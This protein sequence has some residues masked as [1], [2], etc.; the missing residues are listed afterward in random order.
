[1]SLITTILIHFAG[2]AVIVLGASFLISVAVG[3]FI[4]G[5]FGDSAYDRER[6]LR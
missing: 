2:W 3:A 5:G 4:N 1:M 6:D